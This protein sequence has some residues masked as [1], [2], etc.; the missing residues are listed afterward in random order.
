MA[1][2]TVI[3]LALATG[4]TL[5]LPPEKAM[6]LLGQ[7]NNNQ[8]RQK[9]HFS[10]A[11]FFPLKE[12]TTRGYLEIITMEDYL[13]NEALA[14]N[15]RRKENGE[16]LF[17]PNNRT[18]WDQC[19]ASDFDLLKDYLRN[20]SYTPLWSPDD[21]VAVFPSS[22]NIRHNQSA[23]FY[24]M[25]NQI[26]QERNQLKR[27]IP[28]PYNA[29]TME[30]LREQLAGRQELCIYNE[31]M[32]QQPNMHFMCS[33][34]LHVRML[35]HFYAFLFFEDW[36]MDLWIKRFMRDHGTSFDMS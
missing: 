33:P 21:C 2:E 13:E 35:I 24:S 32:Q 3:G 19:S 34:Q 14:G 28:I 30:R 8:Q 36:K 31:F 27:D 5:V 12:I 15:L 6:Y 17:P 20:V 4:R 11:D 16:V 23:K 18:N 9:T 26:V 29:T 7:Q 1:M 25:L 10:F 22:K